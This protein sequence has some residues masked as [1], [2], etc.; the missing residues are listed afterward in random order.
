[1]QLIIFDNLFYNII[2]NTK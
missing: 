1:M 2:I